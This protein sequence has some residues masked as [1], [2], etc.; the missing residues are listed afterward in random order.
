MDW[1]VPRIIDFKKDSLDDTVRGWCE[2]T[3]ST[4]SGPTDPCRFG[5]V[6][7]W[8]CITGTLPGNGYCDSG[9]SA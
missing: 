8:S 9:G 4:T 7:N 1:L 6:A 2:P 3:G 5:G